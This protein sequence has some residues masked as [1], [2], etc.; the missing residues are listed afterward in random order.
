MACWGRSDGYNIFLII[1]SV[2]IV[3]TA[4]AAL[5]VYIAVS[6][7]WGT[8]T[9]LLGAALQVIINYCFYKYDASVRHNA[10]AKSE[11]LEL[12]DQLE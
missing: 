2:I 10:K 7:F 4:V 12:K 11:G 9:G 8:W 6:T 3:G 5:C 1:T